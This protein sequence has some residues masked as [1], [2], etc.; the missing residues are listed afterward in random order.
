MVSLG[1]HRILYIPSHP[2]Q[3][4]HQFHF[5][6]QVNRPRIVNRPVEDLSRKTPF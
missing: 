2:E 3:N 6:Q 5:Q 1:I 4:I